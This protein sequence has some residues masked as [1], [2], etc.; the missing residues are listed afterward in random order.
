MAPAYVKKNSGL[1]VGLNKYQ[2]VI[3][4]NTKT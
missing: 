2:F 3:T 4:N 1:L